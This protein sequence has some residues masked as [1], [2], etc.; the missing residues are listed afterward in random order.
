MVYT[1]CL[2]MRVAGILTSA[3]QISTKNNPPDILWHGPNT[4]PPVY[5]ISPNVQKQNGGRNPPSITR[6]NNYHDSAI[7]IFSILSLPFF[8]SIFLSLKNFKANLR[9]HISSSLYTSNLV[10]KKST[11]PGITIVYL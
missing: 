1:Y 9:H 3:S 5:A 8:S 4:S 2:E 7:F 6:L 10:S 11:F